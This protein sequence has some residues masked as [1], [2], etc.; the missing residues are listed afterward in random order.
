MQ[1]ASG[2]LTV[3]INIFIFTCYF[4][5]NF[6]ELLDCRNTDMTDDGITEFETKVSSKHRSVTEKG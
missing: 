3:N 6:R 1:N 2:D 5:Q 4:S